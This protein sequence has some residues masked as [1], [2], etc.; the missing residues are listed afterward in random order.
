MASDT[1]ECGQDAG[2][3]RPH[4]D[5]NRCEG[6]AVCA[7]ICPYQVYTIGTLPK[8][9]RRGLSAA[10]WLKGYVHRWQQALTVN[11]QACH[12]CGLCI[13]ACPEQAITLRRADP[14]AQ[15]LAAADRLF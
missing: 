4:V 13:A 9:E 1:T 5:R 2:V 6:S 14:P 11:A 8:Q 10:G 3:F 7:A 15:P 12:A